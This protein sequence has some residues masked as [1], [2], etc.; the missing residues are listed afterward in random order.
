MVP[1]ESFHAKVGWSG[2]EIDGTGQYAIPF[3]A[4]MVL[5]LVL[6]VMLSKARR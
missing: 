3:G 1:S 2:F 6:I 5:A 4:A